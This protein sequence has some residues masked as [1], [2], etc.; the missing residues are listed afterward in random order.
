MNV[1]LTNKLQKN[2]LGVA[3][4]SGGVICDDLNAHLYFLFVV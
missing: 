4:A 1:H 3:L 2:I